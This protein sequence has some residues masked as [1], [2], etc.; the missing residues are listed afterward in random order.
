[1]PLLVAS[2]AGYDGAVA[3]LG[4]RASAHTEEEARR[5][6]ARTVLLRLKPHREEYCTSSVMAFVHDA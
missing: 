3:P 1:M 6:A 2:T 4:Q 5:P